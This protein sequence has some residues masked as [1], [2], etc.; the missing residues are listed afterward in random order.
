MT[1]KREYRTPTT[2]VIECLT[3]EMIATSGAYS[4]YG[5]DYGGLDENGS[6]EA[7]TRQLFNFFLFD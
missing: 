1:M 6:M 3:G 7:E 5:I 4:V 2:E